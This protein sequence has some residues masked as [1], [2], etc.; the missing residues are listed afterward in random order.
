MFGEGN[1][2]AETEAGACS[3]SGDDLGLGPV[4]GNIDLEFA[5]IDDY[6]II[7]QDVCFLL[8]VAIEELGFCVEDGVLSGGSGVKGDVSDFGDLF[9]QMGEGPVELILLA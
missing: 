7:T 4:E 3:I 8:G 9:C 5:T 1:H 2:V 6:G